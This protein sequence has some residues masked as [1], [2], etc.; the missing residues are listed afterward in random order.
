MC[1]Q[2]MVQPS[3]LKRRLMYF[4]MRPFGRGWT[5]CFTIFLSKLISLGASGKSVE[6]KKGFQEGDNRHGENVS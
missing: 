1:R 3:L 6:Q 2:M 5:E 4:D